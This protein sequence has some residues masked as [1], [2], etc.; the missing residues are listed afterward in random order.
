MISLYLPFKDTRGD[1]GAKTYLGELGNGLVFFWI[2]L[3][4]VSTSR[5][6]LDDVMI[7]MEARVIWR[8]IV[9]T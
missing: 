2:G 6:M 1:Y 5:E 8:Y 4:A 9:Y 3:Y 7:L